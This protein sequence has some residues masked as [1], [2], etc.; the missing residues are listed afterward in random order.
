[1]TIDAAI[2]RACGTVCY[3]KNTRKLLGYNVSR[4][5]EV[6]R[7]NL[8]QL[9][10]LL[11]SATDPG[12]KELSEPRLD[13]SRRAELEREA[14]AKAVGDARLNADTLLV[15]A[16]GGRLGPVHSVSASCNA[17]APPMPFL[18]RRGVMA[19]AAGDAAQTTERANE[20]HWLC[21]D[22]VRSAR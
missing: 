12:V 22:R 17:V 14:L 19:E 15:K 1:M 21:T 16:A 13:S 11:Q 10:Q 5:I 7:R 9:G 3:N 18:S 2:C 6:D 8:E 4:Q 20:F